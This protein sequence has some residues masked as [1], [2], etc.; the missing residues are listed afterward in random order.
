ME[1]TRRPVQIATTVALFTSTLLLWT[2]GSVGSFPL[3]IRRIRQ[4]HHRTIQTFPTTPTIKQLQPQNK[5]NS[6]QNRYQQ[7]R[8]QE[9]QSLQMS[10]SS[11]LSKQPLLNP[12]MKEAKYTDEIPL[13]VFVLTLCVLP[14]WAFTIL[15]FTILYQVGKE[16][17]TSI[18]SSPKT[19]IVDSGY[20]VD[21][22]TLVPR[23][24]RKYDLVVLGVTGLTGSLA[25]RYLAQTY[26]LNKNNK[27]VKWAV[28]GR[29]ET[30][31]RQ[32]L[33]RLATELQLPELVND[34]D[35]LVVDTSVPSTLPRLVEQTR[36]VATT[37][38]PY[39]LIGSSVIE[40]CAKFGTHYV[41][42]TGEITWIKTMMNLWQTTAQKTGAK[43]IPFCGHDSI[44]WYVCTCVFCFCLPNPTTK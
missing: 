41:D 29:S 33:Q 5:R 14:I 30:K 26:G 21:A 38:G 16:T 24:K 43:I 4:Y 36:V 12:A 40:F 2:V 20:V 15:P 23:E 32:V 42:I 19:T 1:L 34:V 18:L 3:I 17:V 9:Q 27:V 31:I 13:F 39:A 10:S 28:A 8:Q 44:P 35:I 6:L 11:Y 37:A 22:S 25:A 7:Q